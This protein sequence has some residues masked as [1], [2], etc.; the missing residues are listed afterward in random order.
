MIN[1]LRRKVGW[2]CVMI[3]SAYGCGRATASEPDPL[4]GVVEYDDRVIGFEL[5]G[6]VLAVPVERGQVVGADLLLAR[7]DDGL[8]KPVRDLR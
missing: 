8:A 1:N 4:Q 5:G 7:L 6:R 3:S 2:V